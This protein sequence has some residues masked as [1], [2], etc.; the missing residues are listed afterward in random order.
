MVNRRNKITHFCLKREGDRAD[1]PKA[2]AAPVFVE[3]TAILWCEAVINQAARLIL[4]NLGRTSTLYG[5]S[6]GTA[7]LWHAGTIWTVPHRSATEVFSVRTPLRCKSRLDSEMYLANRQL[8]RLGKG[9][10]ARHADGTGQIYPID[11]A[12]HPV[13]GRV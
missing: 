3:A 2:A 6:R 13:P 9:L 1:S 4:R 7:L 10:S 5:F 12:Y 11:R 8:K